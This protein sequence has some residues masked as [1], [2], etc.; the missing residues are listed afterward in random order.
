MSLMQQAYQDGF[1][2][3]G[4]MFLPSNY[5][6]YIV[7]GCDP[8]FLSIGVVNISE[9]YVFYMGELWYV[10]AANSLT[11][12]SVYFAPE[13]SYLPP[14]PISYANS[15]IQNVKEKRV[16]L[17]GSGAL[18]SGALSYGSVARFSQLLKYKRTDWSPIFIFSP[19]VS[20]T[21][22]YQAVFRINSIGEIKLKGRVRVNISALGVGINAIPLFSLPGMVVPEH[23]I[24]LFVGS[25][26]GNLFKLSATTGGL[27]TLSTHNDLPFSQN[28]YVTWTG[29]VSSVSISL[30]LEIILDGIVLDAV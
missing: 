24:T 5:Q 26:D 4:S 9:G 18:P 22:P 21:G 19:N 30:N 23:P 10:A 13:V 7:S 1:K 6:A 29:G 12:G 3:I 17:I 8:T 2:A 16:M 15:S 20:T 28:D 27:V 25:K 11:W 14:T